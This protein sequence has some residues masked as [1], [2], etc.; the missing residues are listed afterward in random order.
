MV[1]LLR[2]QPANGVTVIKRGQRERRI[3]DVFQL[4]LNRMGVKYF[5]LIIDQLRVTTSIPIPDALFI[6][7]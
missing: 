6:R 4:Y 7:Q 2:W 5:S 1:A 3:A